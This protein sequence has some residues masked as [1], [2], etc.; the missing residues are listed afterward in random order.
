[1]IE[2]KHGLAAALATTGAGELPM[3][4]EQ[5]ALLPEPAL[6]DVARTASPAGGRPPGSRNRRTQEWVDLILGQYRSP[7][8]FLA[9]I[10]NRTPQQLAEQADLRKWQPALS[11]ED[12][13]KWVLDTGE[14][15]RMQIAAAKELA[16][17]LH[18][19]LPTA[20]EVSGKSAGVILV[21]ELPVG[22]S[23]VGQALA[24]FGV[25]EL[26]EQNQGVIEA[27][28]QQSDAQQVGNQ[29]N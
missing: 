3:A 7:L 11:G 14:A 1:M 5:L 16:P 17:F 25:G 15:L 19:K 29:G 6:P 12:H 22:D 20:L 21:G 18:Q 26:A 2:G 24:L 4:P 8:L 9:T 13:G 27:Q 28:P 10:Y 23:E